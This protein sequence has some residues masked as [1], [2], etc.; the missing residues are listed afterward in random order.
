MALNFELVVS[1]QLLSVVLAS[2]K[3]FK[4]STPGVG[5]WHMWQLDEKMS[6]ITKN[7][8]AQKQ[9]KKNSNHQGNKRWNWRTIILFCSTAN[10]D[11]DSD[12]SCW[13]IEI[14][15]IKQKL[16]NSLCSCSSWG[17]I[18]NN[19]DISRWKIHEK[20]EKSWNQVLSIFEHRLPK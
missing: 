17:N 7:W 11:L 12:P 13:I 10:S 9:L 5:M 18:W 4:I 20:M 3:W 6:I 16:Q 14:W 15:F 1:D 2:C 19:N 8:D